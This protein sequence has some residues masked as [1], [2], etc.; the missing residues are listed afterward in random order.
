MPSSRNYRGGFV[1]VNGD[2]STPRDLA[3]RDKVRRQVSDYRRWKKRQR[4]RQLLESS[5]FLENARQDDMDDSPPESSTTTQKTHPAAVLKQSSQIDGIG[6]DP[7]SAR[8]PS[9]QWELRSF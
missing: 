6:Q 3:Y 8:D 9:S 2:G 5:K 4:T 1:F 7:T